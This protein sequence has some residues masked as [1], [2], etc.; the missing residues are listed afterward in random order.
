MNTHKDKGVI[1]KVTNFLFWLILISCFSG[2]WLLG[3]LERLWFMEGACVVHTNF[4]EE[5]G[6]VGIFERMA[7]ND[8]GCHWKTN[9]DYR[10]DFWKV[11]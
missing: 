7:C 5:I 3:K 4:R 9:K 2:V 10:C 1:K 8:F 11:K 6:K